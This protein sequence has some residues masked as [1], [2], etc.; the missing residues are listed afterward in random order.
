MT[1]QVLCQ[2]RHD[3]I[4]RSTRHRCYTLCHILN[5]KNLR[6]HFHQS[7]FIYS[8]LAVSN[9]T[10]KTIVIRKIVKEVS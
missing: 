7:T 8:T 3:V 9:L 5:L 10:T 4:R 2:N 6:F 1:H